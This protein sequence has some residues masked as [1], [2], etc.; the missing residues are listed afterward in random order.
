MLMTR[1]QNDVHIMASI[2]FELMPTIPRHVGVPDH[3]DTCQDMCHDIDTSCDNLS[4]GDI[5]DR[6]EEAPESLSENS[7]WNVHMNTVLPLEL[8]SYHIAN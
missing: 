3:A 5:S 4:L 6:F 1:M 7:R 2:V 8:T